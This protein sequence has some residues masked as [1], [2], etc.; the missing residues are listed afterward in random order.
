MV[1]I[2]P[3]SRVTLLPLAVMVMLFKHLLPLLYHPWL[4]HSDGA[5]PSSPLSK[6]LRVRNPLVWLDTCGENLYVV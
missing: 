1:V 2:T 6:P 3:H 5:P 4:S